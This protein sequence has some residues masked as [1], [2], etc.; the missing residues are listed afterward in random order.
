M[1]EIVPV[2]KALYLCYSN[3]GHANGKVDLF[4]VFNAI[5]PARDPHRKGPFVCFSRLIGGLGRIRLHIDIRRATDLELI[6]W[7]G[8][9]ELDFPDRDTLLQVAVTVPQCLFE[10]A[11]IYLVELYCNNTWV[12]DT[13]VRLQEVST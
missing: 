13:T 12:A 1:P 10:K 11:G 2:A 8:V 7:T 4:G 6:D 9:R 3:R 5:R